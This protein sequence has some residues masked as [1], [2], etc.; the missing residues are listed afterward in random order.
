MKFYVYQDGAD[1]YIHDD[2]D[3]EN[4]IRNETAPFKVGDF[5]MAAA[6][7][8]R[9]W[10]IDEHGGRGDICFTALGGLEGPY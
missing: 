3:C 1:F 8:A 7:K 9:S 4:L 5:D 10:F 2:E 6:M